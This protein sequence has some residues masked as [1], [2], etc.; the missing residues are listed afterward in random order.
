MKQEQP[1]TRKPQQDSEQEA[2]ISDI[3]ERFGTHAV[4]ILLIIIAAIIG[5][6]ILYQRGVTRELDASMSLWSANSLEELRQIVDEYP[7]TKTAPRATLQL[8]KAYYD[9][10]SYMLALETYENFLK[11][12]PDNRMAVS[13]R[14]GRIHCLEAQGRLSKAADEFKQLA[15]ELGTDHYAT[16]QALVGRG[17]CLH[18]MQQ[19]NAARKVYENVMV[20]HEQSIWAPRAE[21]LLKLANKAMN[22]E[23]AQTDQKLP[24]TA[25]DSEPAKLAIEPLTVPTNE[26]TAP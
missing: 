25:P 10:G 15:D 13:A 22:Q 19:Y 14:L 24:A 7:S 6:T 8:A 1:T 16:P 18:Q 11:K 2:T 12:Y 4:T 23:K 26:I 20:K 21:A 5:G 9:S 17:R 3:A